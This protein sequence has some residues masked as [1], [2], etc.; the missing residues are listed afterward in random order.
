MML[1]LRPL[2]CEGWVF[3]AV[4]LDRHSQRVGGW[5]IRTRMKKGLA[6]CALNKVIAL[7]RPPKRCTQQGGG[8]SQCCSHDCRKIPHKHRL[9]T[10]VNGGGTCSDTTPVGIFFKC[11]KVELAVRRKWDTRRKVD[12]PRFEYCNGFQNPV[13]D[14]P[15][16][17]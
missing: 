10:P 12:M 3:L 6:I 2:I 9:T 11:T 4:I 8:G 1:Q 13:T 5:T 7:R 14:I 17:E 15:S 16:Q